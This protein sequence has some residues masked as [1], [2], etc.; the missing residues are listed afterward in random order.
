MHYHHFLD[1]STQITIKRVNSDRIRVD[2]CYID[3]RLSLDHVGPPTISFVFRKVETNGSRWTFTFKG[4]Q[5]LVTFD[6][7]IQLSLLMSILSNRQ[8]NRFSPLLLYR[9]HPQ[10]RVRLYTGSSSRGHFPQQELSPLQNQGF[11]P[12]NTYQRP[13]RSLLLLE[14]RIAKKSDVLRV[15]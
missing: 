7:L 1:L 12:T 13:L 6:S 9:T 10:S 8:Q 2:C 11:A 15:P 3:R 4:P 14:I 5:T